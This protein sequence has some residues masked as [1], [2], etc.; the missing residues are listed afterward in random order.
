MK[1]NK[2]TADFLRSIDAEGMAK[3]FDKEPKRIYLSGKI[4]GL[5]KEEIKDSF[6]IARRIV[7]AKYPEAHIFNPADLEEQWPGYTYENYMKLSIQWLLECDCAYFLKGWETS[8]GANLEMQVANAC[9]IKIN[10]I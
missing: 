7:K 6:E 3:F 5:T 2:E 8:R 9:G 4:N 1:T 10:F